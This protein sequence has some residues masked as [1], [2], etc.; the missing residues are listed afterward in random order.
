MAIKKKAPVIPPAPSTANVGF[1][2]NIPPVQQPVQQPTITPPPAPAPSSNRNIEFPPN[3]LQVNITQSGQK[4]TI[5][6]KEYYAQRE[7]EVRARRVKAFNEQY[8]ESL[9]ETAARL[10]EPMVPTTEQAIE[11]W[12]AAHPEESLDEIG[13]FRRAISTT[14]P[15][16]KERYEAVKEPFLQTGAELMDAIRVGVTSGKPTRIKQAEASFAD[17]ARITDENIE[18]VR[19]NQISGTSAWRDMDASIAALVRLEA[20]TVGL[21]K[22]NSRYWIDNGAEL[23]AQILLERQIL[24]IQRL[25]LI[26]A[27]KEN[28]LNQ[29]TNMQAVSR[30]VQNTAGI[31]A[32][33][34]QQ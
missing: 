9:K 2:P 23:E 18:L 30:G 26:E 8:P 15:L 29:I 13:K 32:E 12:K 14:E 19:T 5:P 6:I 34:V 1:T 20:T 17:A 4:S 27:I 25:K 33:E 21:G 10:Q 31:G 7:A 16:T 24:Q 22:A 11:E 3:S 28:E